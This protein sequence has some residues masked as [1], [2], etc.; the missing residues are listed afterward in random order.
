MEVCKEHLPSLSAG[1]GNKKVKVHVGDAADFIDKHKNFFD[2]L[3]TD[4]C[5]PTA[6]GKRVQL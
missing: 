6:P 5:D 1:F 2:V 3:I 4:C